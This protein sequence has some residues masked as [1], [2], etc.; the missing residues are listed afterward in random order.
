MTIMHW[1]NSKRLFD[2]LIIKQGRFVF[3]RGFF[4]MAIFKSFK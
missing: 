1:S 4:T 3:E 2:N